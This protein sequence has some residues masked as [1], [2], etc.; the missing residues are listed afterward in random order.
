MALRPRAKPG[1]G[2]LRTNR[3]IHVPSYGDAAEAL[4]KICPRGPSLSVSTSPD[5]LGGLCCEL[6]EQTGR[7]LVHLVNYRDDD[8]AER[9]AVRLRLPAGQKA[10]SVTLVGPGQEDRPL[11]Y[12]TEE[13]SVTFTVPRVEVYEIAVV[14]WAA[15]P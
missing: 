12:T 6:T 14:T 7:R 2:D 3:V 4:R 15:E 13:G 1:L 9:I 10:T 11:E 8:P 5:S